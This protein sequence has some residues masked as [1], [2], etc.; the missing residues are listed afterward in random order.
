MIKIKIKALLSKLNTT[1]KAVSG[2]GNCLF[3]HIPKTAGTSFRSGVEDKYNVISDYGINSERTSKKLKEEIYAQLNPY[4]LK[5]ILHNKTSYWLFGHVPLQKYIDFVPVQNT[6]S[7]VRSPLKQVVSHYNHFVSHY[8]FQGNLEDFIKK[9]GVLNVQH[10]LLAFLPAGLIG[11]LGITEEYEDSLLMLNHHLQTKFSIKTINVNTAKHITVDDIDVSLQKLILS[12]S[13]LDVKLYKEACFIFKQRLE[14][15]KANQS[16]VYAC[17]KINSNDVVHGCAYFADKD[18]TVILIFHVNNKE[19]K[20]TKAQ[21]F[22]KEYTKA[23]F[24][25]QRYIG[26]RFDLPKHVSHKDSIDVYVEET[27]QKINYQPLTIPM[28]T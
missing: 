9:A 23:N 17:V 26:F 6:V 28:K 12:E 16:W 10:R 20:Q 18:D 19:I 4:A 3:V 11:C 5:T 22:Y 8:D 2:R 15:L 1:S 21:E 24:P 14:Q 25:R 7:F 13:Y 27:G